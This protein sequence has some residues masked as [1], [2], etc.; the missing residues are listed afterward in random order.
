MGLRTGELLNALCPGN[1]GPTDIDHGLHNGHVSPERV[2]FFEYKDGVDVP[3]GQLRFLRALSGDWQEA[4]G[5]RLI[6]V[7]FRILPLH[8]GR[9]ALQPA[10]GWIWPEE[11]R[12]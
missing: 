10:V 7:R 3:P 2:M 1:N 5:D 11:V 4:S 12:Q 9:D 8:G 6:S